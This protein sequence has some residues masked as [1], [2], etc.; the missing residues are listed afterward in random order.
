ME[1]VAL[2]TFLAVVEEGGILAASRRLNTVQSNVTTRIKRLEEEL[3]KD[4]FYRKGRGLDLAPAGQVLQEYAERMVS[5]ERQTHNAVNQIGEQSGE[6]KIGSMESFAAYRLPV[7]LTELRNKYPQ[8][9][10]SVET[11]PTR[12]LVE[13]VRT[14]K[15]DCAIVGGPV[16]SEQ[17]KTDFLLKEELVMASSIGPE[18]AN[19]PLILFRDGC[20]YRARALQWQRECGYPDMQ[21]MEMGTLDGILGCVAAGL[22]FTL[23][24]ESVVEKA[25]YTYLLHLSKVPEHIAQIPINLICH[26]DMQ[27]SAI[28]ESFQSAI[29]VE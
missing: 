27:A 16:K 4:L 8:L 7:A 9:K 1:I 11:H 28:I 18:T 29:I 20:A 13:L 24:P 14:H 5:L 10:L 12:Q 26:R 17:L 21:V 15:L 3:G 6:L 23:L 19:Q 25:S 2:K 22:G